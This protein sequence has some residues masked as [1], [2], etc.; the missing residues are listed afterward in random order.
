VLYKVTVGRDT[1]LGTAEEVVEWMSRAEGAPPGGPA[2]AMRGIAAR[3]AERTDAPRIDTSSPL[4]F[5]LSLRDAGLLRLEERAEAS[6]ERV[7]QALLLDQAL[8]T[9][10]DDV[11][12]SDLDL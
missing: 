6:P 8:L 4:A 5:L 10:A 12:P 2:A 11:D 7:D 9:F 3:V 1:Y